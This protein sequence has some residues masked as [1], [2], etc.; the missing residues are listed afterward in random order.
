MT[1]KKFCAICNI[2]R[3]NKKLNELSALGWVSIRGQENHIHFS[4]VFCPKHSKTKEIV[5]Y[6][7]KWFNQAIK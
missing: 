3:P 1:T 5:D 2:E 6:F 7:E 4:F